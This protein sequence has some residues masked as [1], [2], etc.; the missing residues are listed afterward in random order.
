M[1]CES[2]VF[3][4]DKPAGLTSQQVV[5]RLKR[6]LGVRKAGHAGTLDPAATGVL[7]VGVN[8]ATRLL[9]YIAG[10]Q[11]QYQATIRLGQATT[12]DDAEGEA[13]GE[14]C[15]AT[16]LTDEAIAA[17]IAGLTGEIE[18]VPSA[19]S[20]IKV[21][22]RRAYALVRAGETPELTPRR[23]QVSRFSVEKR[24]NDAPFV[25]LAVVVDCSSG[26]YI[27]ALA[28][29][30][31]A[32]LGSGGHLTQLRRTRVGRFGIDM[33][34]PLDEIGWDD[35]EDLA[36]VAQLAF[37]VFEVDATAVAKIAHGQPLPVVVPEDPTAL[38]S[39]PTEP[40]HP[41]ELLALYRPAG[42]HSV[43]VAVLIGGET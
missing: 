13:L 28:R 35:M 29:D 16:G 30:L 43:P 38:L 39:P 23:V 26:T 7:V 9:G 3:V 27:R 15:D 18:Q 42:D 17:A 31:G 5:A 20:A 33:A 21:A 2:G 6:A 11:K 12:T 40:G 37:P 41:G 25:D 32:R 14:P 22:G 10:T 34:V 8:R 1:K 4:V 36:T 19:V 24:Q